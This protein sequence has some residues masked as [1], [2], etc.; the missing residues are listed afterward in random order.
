MLGYGS[1]MSVARCSNSNSCH[2]AQILG[3]MAAEV[4]IFFKVN[5]DVWSRYYSEVTVFIFPESKALFGNYCRLLS[6]V[7]PVNCRYA[8]VF[9]TSMSFNPTL[10]LCLFRE[11]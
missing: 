5:E 9:L 8:V 3:A 4:F 6:T 1:M 7:W 10:H 11:K 2:L